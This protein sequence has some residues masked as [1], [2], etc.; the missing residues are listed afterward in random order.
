MLGV[1]PHGCWPIIIH[2]LDNFIMLLH[3]PGRCDLNPTRPLIISFA[4]TS[5]LRVVFV[6][7]APLSTESSSCLCIS[8][9]EGG[10]S[11]SV[12]IHTEDNPIPPLW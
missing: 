8:Q 1:D 12:I 11:W 5:T 3:D 7:P 2:T 10:S 6:N 4:F 9:Q